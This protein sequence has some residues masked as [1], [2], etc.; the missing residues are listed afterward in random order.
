[1]KHKII[2]GSL[3][4]VK[5]D[6]NAEAVD[7][8]E[9]I[10]EM[11]VKTWYFAVGF[12]IVVI[13]IVIFALNVNGR[14]VSVAEK[15]LGNP[16]IVLSDPVI[17]PGIEDK[18]VVDYKTRYSD[19]SERDIQEEIHEMANNLVIAKYKIG[20]KK[21]S[22]SK[23]DKLCDV[24]KNGEYVHAEDYL[25][26]LNRWR[27]GDFSKADE[28]HNLVWSM[29]GGEIGKAEGVDWTNLPKWTGGAKQ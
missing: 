12:L 14:D 10:E 9:T 16:E 1:M 15:L 13:I 19:Y 4:N 22:K 27:E 17:R 18:E 29:L 24:I 28:D 23:L 6:E 2:D 26:I 25:D 8:V 7:G 20:F 5:T 11:E 21:I 3:E